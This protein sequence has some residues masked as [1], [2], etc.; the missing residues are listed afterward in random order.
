MWTSGRKCNYRGCEAARFQ[1]AIRNGWLWMG[2]KTA[3]PDP[4]NRALCPYCEW[5]PKGGLG[6]PQPDNREIYSKGRDEACV[7]VLN[8]L[9]GDGLKWH[10]I[11]C[12]HTKPFIC[13]DSEQLLKYARATSP[14][15]NIF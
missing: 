1:P 7:A 13:E 2:R 4:F 12:Y 5:S 14:E 8:N 3:I 10:D 15:L 6:V 9:Y 11:A